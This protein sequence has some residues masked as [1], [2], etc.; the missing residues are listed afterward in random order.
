MSLMMLT[1]SEV[2][3]GAYWWRRNNH[4]HILQHMK[5][6]TSQ[7]IADM[8]QMTHGDLQRFKTIRTKWNYMARISLWSMLIIFVGW[9]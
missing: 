6:L 7:M 3:A 2:R 4:H 9:S 5:G 1:V 8:N